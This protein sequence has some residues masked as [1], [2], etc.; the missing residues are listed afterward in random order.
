MGS[1]RSVPASLNVWKQQKKRF[2]KIRHNT[3]LGRDE[4]K[5]EAGR[6]REEAHPS[7]TQRQRAVKSSG[8]TETKR[9]LSCELLK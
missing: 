4:R 2:L 6:E 9:R 5:E 7:A 1:R 3:E 8:E